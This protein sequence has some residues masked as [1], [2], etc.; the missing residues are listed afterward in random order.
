MIDNDIQGATDGK[1][2]AISY[3]EGIFPSAKEIAQRIE[4]LGERASGY[5]RAWIT[6]WRAQLALDAQI[7]TEA[8]PTPAEREVIRTKYDE[9]GTALGLRT[10]TG[11]APDWLPKDS[12]PLGMIKAGALFRDVNRNALMIRVIQRERIP[13]QPLVSAVSQ[14]TREAIWIDPWQLVVPLRTAD[15]TTDFYDD[16][17]SE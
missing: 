17:P 4:V 2:A 13:G 1:N 5:E 3:R 10:G 12:V 8:T 6:A 16:R 7:A 9:L 11:A 15:V 14:V